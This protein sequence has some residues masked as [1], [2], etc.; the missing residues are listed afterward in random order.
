M[1]VDDWDGL[2]P[3]AER[4]NEFEH[5]LAGGVWAAAA[6]TRIPGLPD[7]VAAVRAIYHRMKRPL[8]QKLQPLNSNQVLQRRK[9][10]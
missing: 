9:S 4:L 10:A 5:L 3:I 1:S 8:P 6:A 2:P 7:D